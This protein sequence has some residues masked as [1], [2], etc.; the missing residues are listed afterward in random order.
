MQYVAECVGT[1]ILVLL[2]DGVVANVNLEKSNM[3]GGGSVQITIAWGLAVLIPVCIFSGVSGAQFN[4]AV[5]IAMALDGKCS[6]SIVPGYIAAQLLGGWIGAV[7]VYLFYKD[8]LDAT[9]D[10]ATKLCCFC[11]KPGVRNLPRNFFCEAT[12]TFILV[13]ALLGFI[14][15]HGAEQV[16]M[17]HILV[18]SLIVSIGMSLG[19]ATGYAINPARDLAPRLAHFILPMKDKGSSDWGYAFVPVAGP[20]VGGILAVFLFKVLFP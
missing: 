10:P 11:T 13:F 6:W 17:D 19:G 20:I 15:V 2:G 18:W 7:M 5:T 9:K 14:N 8:Q 3:K 1:A 4:P 12:A 16:G